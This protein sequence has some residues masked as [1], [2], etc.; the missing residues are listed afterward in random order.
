MGQGRLLKMGGV[1]TLTEDGIDVVLVEHGGL[2]EIFATALPHAADDLASLLHRLRRVLQDYR[3]EF[4]EMRIFGTVGD[5]ASCT[6]L[7][8]ELYGP[9]DWP[10][11]YIQGASCFG[12]AVAG[13]Q[14]HAVAGAS[15]D[16]LRRDGL[17]VGRVFEDDF[18]RYCVLGNL[19]SSDPPRPRERQTRDTIG[20]LNGSL[21]SAGM[22]IHNIVRTWFFIDDILGWYPAFNRVRSEIYAAEGV[23]DRYVPASTGIGGYR[24]SSSKGPT[25]P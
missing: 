13:I 5:L 9:I 10:L 6:R 21:A 1:G 2:T 19:Q 14:L 22:D 20:Q 17:P 3:G 7:L 12:D 25:G 4:L 18:A 16:T 11:T 8:R 15:V 24:D 23:F